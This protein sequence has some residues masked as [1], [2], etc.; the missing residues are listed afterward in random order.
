MVSFSDQQIVRGLAISIATLYTESSC[1]VD[2]Y[3]Y[4]ILCYLLLMSIVSH[5]SSILVL[6][7]YVNGLKTLSVV[8]FSMAFA[9]IFFAGIIFSSR[10]T[11]FFP[12]R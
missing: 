12:T 1:T 3:R 4:N 5:L 7:S 11:D 2:A 9:Q 8:R 6:R 10:V